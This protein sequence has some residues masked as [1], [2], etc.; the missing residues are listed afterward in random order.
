MK[1]GRPTSKV[2][3]SAYHYRRAIFFTQILARI[4]TDKWRTEMLSLA[5]HWQVAHDGSTEDCMQELAKHV[6]EHGR[7]MRDDITT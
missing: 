4:S 6:I 7:R 2:I 5:E 1:L 3:P